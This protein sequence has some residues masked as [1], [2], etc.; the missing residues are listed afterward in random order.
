MIRAAILTMS[1]KGSRG[2]RMDKSGQVI[3][4]MIETLPAEIVSY[5]IIPDERDIIKERLIHLS[6]M[7]KAD[8]IITTGGT[9]I[10]PRDVT[11]DVTLDIIDKEV[12]G[13]AEAMRAESLKKAPTSMISRAVVGTRGETLI[14]NLPGSPK[15]VRENLS[16]VLPAIPH[17][18]EKLKGDQRDCSELIGNN[19]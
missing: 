8:L 18:I 10:S 15:A 19:Q 11:P 3:K 13:M 5:E 7:T 14:I 9:G 1:D 4:E 17:A 6:D 16:A 2:E 12:P